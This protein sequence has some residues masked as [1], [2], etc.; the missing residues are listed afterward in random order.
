MYSCHP[1]R[2]PDTIPAHHEF[3]GVRISLD[4]ESHLH[5]ILLMECP[6]DL[7]FLSDIT[8]TSEMC[9]THSGS[10]FAACNRW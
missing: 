2:I 7:W 6:A 5:H 9:T 10:M 4:G 3:V 8:R 1:I